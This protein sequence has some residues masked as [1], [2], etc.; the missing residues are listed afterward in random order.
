MA[1]NFERHKSTRWVKADV[2]SYGD[3][4]GN[5]YDYDYNEEEE[6]QPEP[7]PV[8]IHPETAA[9]RPKSSNPLVL[10]IDHV[11]RAEDSSDNEDEN[12]LE[13]DPKESV[14]P[15]SDSS[16]N[17][18]DSLVEPDSN[19]RV[20]ES[21]KASTRRPPPVSTHGLKDDSDFFPPTPTFS[22]SQFV[23]QSPETPHSDR[24]YLSDADSIQREPVNLNL[25]RKADLLKEIQ[26]APVEDSGAEKAVSV[27]EALVLSVDRMNLDSSDDS[28]DDRFGFF[29]GKEAF[30][31]G[32][33]ANY[34][35]YVNPEVSSSEESLAR[36]DDDDWGYNSQ[37]SSNEDTENED[38][39]NVGNSRDARDVSDLRRHVKTDALDS[40][41]NDL[42]QMER[43]SSKSPLAPT[44]AK[45]TKREV[46][47]VLPSLDSIHDMSLP[48]FENHTFTADTGDEIENREYERDL[49]NRESE[50]GDVAASVFSEQVAKDHESYISNFLGRV[51]SVRKA[52]PT[53]DE[54]P[55]TPKLSETKLPE[56]PETRVPETKVPESPETRVPELL[57]TKVTELPES[58]AEVPE[59]RVPELPESIP[60]GELLELVPVLSTGS[61]STGK[62]SIDPV[63][64]L[65]NT[66][67]ETLTR[68]VSTVSTATFNLGTWKP[69]TNLFRD[70]FINDNDNESQMNY[71]M[72]NS[73]EANY[74][75]FTGL[76]PGS[77]Y[78]ESFANSSCL[79]VPETVDANL[80]SIEENGSEN[81]DY[82]DTASLPNSSSIQPIESTASVLRNHS[83]DK[84]KFGEERV[85][86]A[87]SHDRLPGEDTVKEHTRKSSEASA[88][89]ATRRISD[90]SIAPTLEVKK[91]LQK[92]PT[93]KWKQ[94]MSVSQPID[95]IQLLKQARID[96]ANFDT[97]LVTWLHE[98]LKRSE[99]SSNI[100]IGRI[101][102]EAYQNAQHS[103]LRRH[104]SIR[105]KV[106]LVKD[107]MDTGNIGLQATNFGRRFL[108]KG[109]KLMKSGSD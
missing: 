10:S 108:S 13:Q 20:P 18:P 76:R 22:L 78:A 31:K 89:D 4:W 48:D 7:S 65:V 62:V 99:V 75:K 1:E 69:N 88:T 44:L 68:N 3:Q 83:Y 106:S 40:L 14:D 47:G 12:E 38:E 28:D 90:L 5:E 67:S 52:P 6:N 98:N 27:P 36:D 37:H 15:H 82:P 59:S 35:E 46:Q 50:S 63:N 64:S 2:P 80:P 19:F 33:E 23:Q 71:S 66:D 45:E 16:F 60:E 24:S 87:G 21:S 72:D 39:L 104:T 25:A 51:A 94:I 11:N 49:E 74:S 42:L 100:H 86:L 32:Y 57:E 81:G 26:E 91:P 9:R 107:K 95:R 97:G 34:D 54:K 103:D 58:R 96:E 85:T 29:E 73:N 17:A 8:E 92:Y 53:F 56:F 93:Y 101:A 43:L 30:E 84:P 105:S 70:Q 55:E 41:I 102:T 61:V 77:G 79:S 109:K